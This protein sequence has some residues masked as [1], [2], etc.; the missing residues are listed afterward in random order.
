MSPVDYDTWYFSRLVVIVARK[1]DFLAAVLATIES[2]PSALPLSADRGKLEARLSQAIGG[3]PPE[4]FLTA[5]ERNLRRFL[6]PAARLEDL[7]RDG[8]WEALRASLQ[9]RD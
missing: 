9:P 2:D 3:L 1:T 5:T 6:N 8:I 7:D 4:L